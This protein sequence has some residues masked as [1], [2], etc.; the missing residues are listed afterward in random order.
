M[1]HLL[2][3]FL[4]FMDG[5][6]DHLKETFDLLCYLDTMHLSGSR[7]EDETVFFQ[8]G[9]YT[10]WDLNPTT[11][12]GY[13]PDAEEGSIYVHGW[14]RDQGYHDDGYN[15]SCAVPYDVLEDLEGY[16]QTLRNEIDTRRSELFGE[17]EEEVNRNKDSG[18]KMRH[19]T[20][21]ELSK[22]FGPGMGESDGNS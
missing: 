18:K 9:E 22:E 14:V 15:T 13:S 8:T 7:P 20:W 16:N 17:R 19:R 6:E 12:N 4:K 21:L 3:D 2:T 11:Y 5:K 10:H 1:I